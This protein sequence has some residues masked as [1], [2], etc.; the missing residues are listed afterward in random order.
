[1]GK[2]HHK[3]RKKKE[4][5]PE[6]KRHKRD[7][8]LRRK[9]GITLHEYNK[10]D[11]KQKHKCA[12]CRRPPKKLPL[13]VDHWHWLARRKVVSYKKGKY[14]I[15]KVPELVPANI[16]IRTKDK[17]RRKAIK[18]AKLYLLRISVRG[19]LCWHCNTALQKF[20]DNHVDLLAA[21]AYL[22]EYGRKVG[23]ERPNI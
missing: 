18:A 14:W 22:K 9:Y 3:K 8:Y 5:T 1:V 2:K 13:A 15:A 6:E 4:L 11:R 20:R 21:S 23:C 7:T 16:K 17:V 12:I 19:L 10:M